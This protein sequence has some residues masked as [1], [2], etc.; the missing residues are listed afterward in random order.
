MPVRAAFTQT[1]LSWSSAATRAERLFHSDTGPL[2]KSRPAKPTPRTIVE[3]E[4]KELEGIWLETT[5]VAWS[6]E[7]NAVLTKRLAVDGR[8]EE[9]ARLDDDREWGH[10]PRS[11]RGGSI[12][13]A[14]RHLPVEVPALRDPLFSC[15]TL[16]L[17]CTYLNSECATP[18]QKLADKFHS[19]SN[20]EACVQARTYAAYPR[21]EP[22]VIDRPNL[23]RTTPVL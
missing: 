16:Q 19:S 4:N 1:L 10:S 13:R 17:A 9:S 11:A 23:G 8:D 21:D 14:A 22:P 2:G 7:E 12:E 3:A 6:R 5:E 18:L 20:V 15:P